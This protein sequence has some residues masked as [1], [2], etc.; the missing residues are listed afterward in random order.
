MALLSPGWR[1]VGGTFTAQMFVIGFFTYAVSLL[2]APVREEFGVSLEQVMYSLTAG[3]IMGLFLQPVGG[4]L[5][6]RVSVGRIMGVG[7]LLYALGLYGLANSTSLWQYII[8]FG[9]TM[10]AANAFCASLTS[11]AV[12]SRWF[13]RRRGMALGIAAVGTSVG[14]VIIP[15]L[16]SYW[17]SAYGW[18][19]ALE[20]LALSVILVMLPMVVFNIK[21]R[22]GSEAELDMADQGQAASTAPTPELGMADIARNPR[23]WLIG[24]SLGLLF[25]SYTATL[26][27]L[28]PYA[29]NAGEGEERASTLIMAVAIFGL[30]G[31][32]LFGMAADRISLKMGLW[33]AQGMVVL[34]LLLL[35]AQPGYVLMLVATS[36]LGLAAGGMLPV[37]GAMMAQAFGLASYGRAMGL[38]GPLITLCVMPSFPIMGR[39]VDASG[40]YTSA[41]HL[42]SGV[43]VVAALLL[44]PLRLPKPV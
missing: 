26:S 32:L 41:L 16:I 9:I 22:P 30:L 1:V 7:T 19:T 37:W 29:I 12:I 31:K 44:L 2:V 11:S 38:M 40:S 17:L 42:F 36:L 14:G 6:D 15:A 20:L 4:I 3:T 5:V 23:F 18:R 39:L 34:A 28:T 8:L 27:N 33:I 43:V 35:A 10:A 13:T 25:A 24:L 21:D